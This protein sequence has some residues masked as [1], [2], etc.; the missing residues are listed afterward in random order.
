MN[1]CI[2]CGGLLV[3]D[4]DEDFGILL[5]FKRCLNCGWQ[6]LGIVVSRG[7]KPFPLSLEIAR[8]GGVKYIG[9]GRKAKYD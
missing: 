6:S 9:R 4:D 7:Y 5:R 3:E 8:T 2:K 1:G